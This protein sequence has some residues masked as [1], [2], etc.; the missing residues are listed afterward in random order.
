MERTTIFDKVSN[1]LR[2]VL[3]DPNLILTNDMT[4]SDV[5]QWDSLSHMVIIVEIEEMFDI[6]IKLKEL[7]KMRNIGDMV[8][9]IISKL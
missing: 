4:A 5:S 7:N 1:V 2:K 9:I 8:D 3:N 6:K